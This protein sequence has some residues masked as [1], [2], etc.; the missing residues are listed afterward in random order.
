MDLFAQPVGYIMRKD[1][2]RSEGDC[3]TESEFVEQY[4]TKVWEQEGGPKAQIEKVGR[5]NEMQVMEPYLAAMTSKRVLDI[6]CGLGDWVM[7]FQDRGFDITGL[8][9]SQKTISNLK[10]TFNG[11]DFQ[12]GD[13]RKTEYDDNIFDMCFSWGVFEHFENGP[14]ECLRETYRILKP[15]GLLF[16]SVPLDNLRMSIK[17][18]F[19]S[20]PDCKQEER[21]YQY[22]FTRS[23]WAKE[24]QKEG[25]IIEETR[26][27]HKRQGVLRCLHHEFGFSYDWLI[28]R[29]LSAVISPFVPGSWIGHMQIGVARKPF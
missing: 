12:V 21:F 29:A 11:Y 4:W 17:G 1:H 20:I 26:P 19:E 2:I 8:D 7:Y 5:A 23:E 25:F 22:R 27:I 18:T 13:I 14:G 3:S 16:A 10:S 15:G 9:I 24:F 6:G 28:T